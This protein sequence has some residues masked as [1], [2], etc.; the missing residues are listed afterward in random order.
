MT[1]VLLAARSP[2]RVTTVAVAP[3]RGRRGAVVAAGATV[4]APEGLTGVAARERVPVGH[5]GEGDRPE[6]QDAQTQADPRGTSAPLVAEPD[7]AD[8][9]SRAREGQ[10]EHHGRCRGRQ[11]G[12]RAGRRPRGRGRYAATPAGC[13]SY[14][15]RNSSSRAV[16]GPA[17]P[18]QR[19]PLSAPRP[20][21]RARPCRGADAAGASR[22][23]WRPSAP[24]RAGTHQTQRD[25][26]NCQRGL[27]GLAG[28]R[29]PRVKGNPTREQM[30]RRCGPRRG[31]SARWQA[32]VVGRRPAPHTQDGHWC[33]GRSSGVLTTGSTLSDRLGPEIVG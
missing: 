6:Q 18:V 8:G 7:E 26:G 33:S 17:R 32:E 22:A 10:R 27:Q 13:C 28:C 2:S 31:T 23:R 11:V 19:Q 21:R 16:T 14:W 3:P 4:G 25:E 24:R 29:S 30:P 12:S 15:S 9:R 20:A 5:A 1:V